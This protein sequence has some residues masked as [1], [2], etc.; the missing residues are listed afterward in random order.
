MEFFV[1][2]FY[3]HVPKVHNLFDGAKYCRNV[4]VSGHGATTS[5]TTDSKTD[6]LTDGS[7][8]KANVT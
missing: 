3:Y 6:R 8:H 7:C 5:Q 1:S 4:R 2:K